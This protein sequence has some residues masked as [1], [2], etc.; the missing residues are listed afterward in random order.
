M[1]THDFQA[2]ANR[3]GKY[4][5]SLVPKNFVSSPKIFRVLIYKIFQAKPNIDKKY[6]TI[7]YAATQKSKHKSMQK[8]TDLYQRE[9]KKL[10]TIKIYSVIMG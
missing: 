7:F 2:S 5:G 3:G 1:V 10:D 8:E 9:K 6:L 4:I